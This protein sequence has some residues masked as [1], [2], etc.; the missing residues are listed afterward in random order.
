M[1]TLGSSTIGE[2][3]EKKVHLSLFA[4]KTQNTFKPPDH[5]SKGTTRSFSPMHSILFYHD[6]L[7]SYSILIISI[8][9]VDPIR[10]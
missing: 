2:M 8:H 6:I 7:L 10:D 4:R 3:K 5:P 1:A 9:S